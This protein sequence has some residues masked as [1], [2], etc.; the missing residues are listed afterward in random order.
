MSYPQWLTV[1]ETAQRLHLSDRMV[2]HLIQSGELRSVK[3]GRARRIP[4]T[5]ICA[6]EA[7]LLE[8]QG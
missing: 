2:Q 7:R 8:K 1:K 3:V 5:E 4:S 6:Y